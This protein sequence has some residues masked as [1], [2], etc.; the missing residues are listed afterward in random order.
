MS[1]KILYGNVGKVT[2]IVT[3]LPEGRF[4]S[5]SERRGIWIWNADGTAHA[6]LDEEG[7]APTVA[8]RLADGRLLTTGFDCL[9]RLWD[10]REG[11]EVARERLKGTLH[12]MIQLADGRLVGGSYLGTVYVWELEGGGLR[13][14]KTLTGHTGTIVSLAQL[15][16]GRL[17]SGDEFGRVMLQEV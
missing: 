13:R 16:D 1:A 3:G 9:I 10:T 17:L 7:V 5:A 12:A 15:P 6:V 11:K 14:V 4:A 8:F 2:H